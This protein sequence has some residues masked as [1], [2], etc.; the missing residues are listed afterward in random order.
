MSG[1][2]TQFLANALGRLARYSVALGVA[3]TAAQ[4]SLFVVH[5]GHRA[6]VFNRFTG[7]EEKVRGEVRDK[8]RLP[9]PRY[10][11]MNEK[12]AQSMFCF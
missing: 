1:G 10:M 2:S 12:C 8:M 4:N 11:S 7:V 9:N 3:A 6:V 5:G